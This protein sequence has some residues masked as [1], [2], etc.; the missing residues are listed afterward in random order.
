M[1]GSQG[2]GRAQSLAAAARSG[3]GSV[4]GSIFAYTLGITDLGPI[5]HGL[6]FERFPSS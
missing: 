6:I 5:A 4:A 3:R 1:T 2:A